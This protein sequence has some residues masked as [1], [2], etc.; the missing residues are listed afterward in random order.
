M[1][2]LGGALGKPEGD[3]FFTILAGAREVSYYCLGTVLLMETKGN[4][5]APW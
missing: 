4:P 3:V 2:F 5:P 1:Y